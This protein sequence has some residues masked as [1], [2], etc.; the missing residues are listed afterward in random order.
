MGWEANG[1]GE[2]MVRNGRL[3]GGEDDE[4]EMG[5]GGW[6]RRLGKEMGWEVEW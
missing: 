2:R 4:V 6:G 5:G 1:W 3:L